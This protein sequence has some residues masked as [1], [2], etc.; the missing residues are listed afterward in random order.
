[1]ETLEGKGQVEQ[2]Q[3]Q[4]GVWSARVEGFRCKIN[5]SS[6]V[7]GC[8]E[9]VVLRELMSNA[10]VGLRIEQELERELQIY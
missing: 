3:P 6:E 7:G 9:R 10:V 4:I 2:L 8:R 1:M 5:I